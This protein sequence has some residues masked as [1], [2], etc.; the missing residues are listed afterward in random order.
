VYITTTQ[1]VTEWSHC[2]RSLALVR[3]DLGRFDQRGRFVSK[4]D[5]L[6]GDVLTVGRFDWIPDTQCDKLVTE[7]S[8]Q[9]FASKVADF[10]LP[11][12]HL[13]YITCI[14]RLRWGDPVLFEFCW[15]FWHQKTRVPGLSCGVTGVILRLAVSAEHRLVT[16][17]L[18]IRHTTAANIRAS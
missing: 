16:D 18:T 8:W 1:S 12:P 7:L 3:F 5:V 9:R 10:Q 14:W 2:I 11:H 13:S 4:R 6:T 15:D 17:G